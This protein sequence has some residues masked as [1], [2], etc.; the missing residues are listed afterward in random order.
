MWNLLKGKNEDCKRLQNGLEEFAAARPEA[1]NLKELLAAMAPAER[2]HVAACMECREAVQDIF[3]S[4]E[5]IKSAAFRG[6]EATPGFATR[7]MNAIAAQERELAIVANAWSEFPR[8]ASRLA[9]AAG[10]LLL[11]GSTW[12]YEKG[13]PATNHAVTGAAAQESLFDSAPP[14]NQDDVLISM[15]ES[16]R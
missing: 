9:W 7:V 13:V 10:I 2:N 12:L 3:S 1:V 6:V 16:N 14:A 8:F 15:A 11:A 4:R 5:I